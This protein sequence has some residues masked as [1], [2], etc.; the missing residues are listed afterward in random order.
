MRYSHQRE[1]IKNIVCS[2]KNHPSADWVYTETK[3]IIK[4]ISLGTVYR[5]LKILEQIEN[6]KIIYDK[7]QARYDG[8]TNEHHHLKCLECGH[9]IDIDLDTNFNRKKILA[10]HEFEPS[11]VDFFILGKCNKHNKKR[12]MK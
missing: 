2:T 8:N 6:I 3:K 10:E 7:D 4:N 1:V 11:Q 9:L 5:N 12:S